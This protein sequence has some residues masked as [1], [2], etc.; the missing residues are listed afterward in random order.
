MSQTQDRAANQGQRSMAPSRLT[1]LSN[2]ESPS[3]EAYRSLRASVKFAGVEPAIRSV[4]IADAGSAGQHSAVAS[5]LAAA[6]ALGGDSVVLID[7][8]LRSPGLHQQ[9]GLANESGLGNWLALGDAGA[10][11]P[12]RQTSIEHLQLL[13][14]GN[15]AG[16]GYSGAAPVDYLGGNGFLGLLAR[17]KEQADFLVFDAAPLSQVGDALAIAARVD[18]VLLL[19]RSGRTK[20]AAAQR[21]KESLDRIGARVLGAVLTDAGGR[22]SI[23]S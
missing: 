22:F 15:I 12:L 8:N 11:I 23:R 9:F 13:T 7:A 5:N 14:A 18:A 3:A 6:L 4:L 2:P 17:L 1:L 16:G 10:A 21:A 19:I 20:R